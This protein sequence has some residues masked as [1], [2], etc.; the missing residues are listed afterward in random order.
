MNRQQLIVFAL[1]L[2]ISTPLFAQ[3]QIPDT[4]SKDKMR[5]QRVYDYADVLTEYQEKELSRRLIG[6]ADTTSTQIV[7]ATISSL[8][9]DDISLLGARWGTAWGVGQD[10]EDNG[11]FILLSDGDREIDISTG[12]G[13]EYRMTDLE[14]KAIIDKVIIPEFKKG[15]YYK[16]LDAGVS[17]IFQAIEGEFKGTESGKGLDIEWAK[18][19]PM[20]LFIIIF[21]LLKYFQYKN[22][23]GRGGGNRGA[24]ATSFL[25]YIV[26][27]SEGRSSGSYG[28]SGGG[29]GGGTFGGGSFGGGSFGGGGASGSW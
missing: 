25:E 15:S 26:L 23:G 27:T 21:I 8:K 19:L 12:Y 9:G 7:I 17:A 3:F 14:T 24:A 22:R 5:T 11:I 6:Y 18:Y 20:L 13:I 29:F 28:S 16:G 2:L 10:Q 4:P 1:V